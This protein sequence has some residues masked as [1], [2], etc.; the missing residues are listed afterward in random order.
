MYGYKIVDGKVIV[1]EQEAAV[2]INI[3]NGYLS[4]MSLRDAATNA[5]RPMVHSMVKRIISNFC[6]VGDD[7]YPAIVSRQTFARANAELIRRS[8]KHGGKKRLQLPPVYTEFEISEPEMHFD[9]PI[10]QAEYIYS[11]IGVRK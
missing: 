4:G 6:Y 9:D 10:K 8:E 2:V 3:F 11:L 1:D 7:F 5:G